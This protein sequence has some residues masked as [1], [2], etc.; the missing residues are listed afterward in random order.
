MAERAV[1]AQVGDE[2]AVPLRVDRVTGR[3]LQRAE[4]RIGSQVQLLLN[5]T[6]LSTMRTGAARSGGK[7]ESA[8]E[9][10][11]ESSASEIEA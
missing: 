3:A 9:E 5:P 8:R 1:A 7:A 11:I 6:K 2:C 10:R 4:S